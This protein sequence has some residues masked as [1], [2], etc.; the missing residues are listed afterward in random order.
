MGC[1]TDVT[2]CTIADV[3]VETDFTSHFSLSISYNIPERY[4]TP[5]CSR[6]HLVH[7]YK[8]NHR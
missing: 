1:Y 6:Q 8:T 2:M 5:T 7:S 4:Y 3:L